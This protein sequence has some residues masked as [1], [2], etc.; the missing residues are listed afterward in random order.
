MKNI[1]VVPIEPIETR[2]TCEWFDYIPNLLKSEMPAGINVINIVGDE[3][4]PVPSQGAFLDFGA[5]NVYK[6]SQL[7]RIADMF[8]N[9]AVQAGDKFLF[10]DYWNPCIIQI[11]YMSELLNIPV[12]IHTL[13]HA[14]SYD[15]WDFL[16]RLIKDKRWTNS[17]EKAMFHAGDYHWFATDYHVSLFQRN[18]FGRGWLQQEL[19]DREISEKFCRT[20]WPMD[21]MPDTLAKYANVKKENIIIFPHRLAPEKQPEIF[22]DLKK[23][24]P[25]Y[26]FVVCQ[27]QKLS[28]E[29]YHTLLAKSK[30]MFSANLQETLGISPFEGALL[31]VVPMVPDRLSYTEMYPLEYKYP[32]KW[33]LSFENYLE[34][35]SEII[36]HIRAIMEAPTVDTSELATSLL[37]DYFTASN[38][39]AHLAG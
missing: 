18:V 1:F 15:P 9:G 28:K 33:T 24:L 25:E 4:P 12:E 35:K 21:Y 5:T 19:T 16:G 27:D 32:S 37:K 39:I 17:T 23:S 3:V 30:L 10:T 22:L 2:Y 29:E 8:R 34:H 13:V 31:N 26:E 36:A 7:I 20:G 38:L 14:G 6:S 11:K